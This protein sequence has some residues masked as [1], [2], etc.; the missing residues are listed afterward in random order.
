MN[1][2]LQQLI[3]EHSLNNH[4]WLLNDELLRTPME[5]L[6]NGQSPQGV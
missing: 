4:L 5:E 3:D 6:W 1:K 2:Y